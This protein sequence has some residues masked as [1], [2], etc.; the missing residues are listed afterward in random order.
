MKRTIGCLL[1]F[2]L[3]LLLVACDDGR[4]ER[5]EAL[6]DRADSLNRAYIP[7]TGGLDT[8]LLEATKYYDR[9]GTPNEQ[10]RAHYLLGCAYRDMGEAPAALQSFQ[11]AADR[12]DTLNRDCD[13]RRLMSVYGQ[14]ADLFHA[15]NLPTDELEASSHVQEFAY[16][17]RDTLTFIRSIELK[18]RPYFL[19]YDTISMLSVLQQAQTLYNKYGFHQEAS[20]IYPS[21][22]DLYISQDSLETA[23]RLM[24]I[25][26]TKSGLFDAQGNISAGREGYYEVKGL[27]Y[28]RVHRLDSAEYYFRRLLNFDMMTDA[29]RGLFSVYKDRKNTD[30][31]AKYVHLYEKALDDEQDELSTQTIHQMSSLYNYTRYQ[32]EAQQKEQEAERFK[33]T[34]LVVCALTVILVLLFIIAYVRHRDEKRHLEDR[35]QLLRG[36]AVN[37]HLYNSPIAQRFRELLKANPYQNPDL[38]DWKELTSLIDRE[39][40]SFRVKLQMG[41]RLLSDVEYD[42]CMLIKIQISSS[43]IA[44]LKR[45]TPSNVTHIRERIF[46]TLFRKKGKADELDEY[47]MSLT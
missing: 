20:S 32:R 23:K 39:V 34:L 3:L 14:M 35:I 18:V 29:Y 40:P 31:I 41:E 10:M 6:L 36:Y 46:K 44:R 8:M 33:N 45:Y 11:D 7:M 12:A 25:F 30:S 4:R 22:I 38:K 43:D 42:V 15:Q 21:I 37:E 19:L 16:R 9:H 1:T 17:Q 24:D 47:I 26:E 28:L 5:M 13:Y 2:L 27:Y